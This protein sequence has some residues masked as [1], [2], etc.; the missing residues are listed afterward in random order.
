MTTTYPEWSPPWLRI[1]DAKASVIVWN[2]LSG[3]NTALVTCHPLAPPA[4]WIADWLQAYLARQPE[5]IRSSSDHTF[6]YLL[7]AAEIDLPAPN[8]IV[9]GTVV[10]ECGH[11]CAPAG[12][13]DGVDIPLEDL[14]AGAIAALS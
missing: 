12:N 14:I 8:G 7:V 10:L 11:G 1:D 3:V 5:P 2:D 9:D 13:P 4:S 6:L